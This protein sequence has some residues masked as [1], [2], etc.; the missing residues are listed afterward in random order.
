[1]KQASELYTARSG[2][3]SK[4]NPRYFASVTLEEKIHEPATY[5]NLEV[6]SLV[7][8]LGHRP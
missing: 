1:M 5:N 8:L 2:R 7:N 3:T 6:E 4:P